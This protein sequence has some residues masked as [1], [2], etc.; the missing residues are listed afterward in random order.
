MV[1]QVAGVVQVMDLIF[2]LHF[3]IDILVVPKINRLIGVRPAEE[4]HTC[5][6]AL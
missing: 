1:Q 6:L 3:K 5:C 4:V 2:E